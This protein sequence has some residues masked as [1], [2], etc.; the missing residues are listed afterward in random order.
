MDLG[1][2]PNMFESFIKYQRLIQKEFANMRERY[3]FQL[4]DGNRSVRAVSYELKRGISALIDGA[5][6]S[7]G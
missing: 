5:G 2:S 6:V 1:L 3:G 7:A 4:V